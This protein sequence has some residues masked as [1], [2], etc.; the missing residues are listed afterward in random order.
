MQLGSLPQPI[1]DSFDA[2]HQFV[3]LGA[4]CEELGHVLKTVDGKIHSIIISQKVGFKFD[5]KISHNVL[6]H[7][8]LPKD[9]EAE[10]DLPPCRDLEKSSNKERLR[11]DLLDRSLFET[12]KEYAK[13]S[14]V[15]I[16]TSDLR[17][18]RELSTEGA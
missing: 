10:L 13:I 2:L 6:R 16:S 15:I 8:F 7:I 12:L 17:K 3:Y 14:E 9:V 11:D 1:G 5:D 4:G 18:Q